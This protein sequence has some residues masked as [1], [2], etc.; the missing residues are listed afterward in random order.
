MKKFFAVAILA[1]ATLTMNAQ[2]FK[3]FRFGP[4]A[5]MTVSKVTDLGAKFG[6]GFQAG[7]RAD[8][9]FNDNFYLGS[10]FMLAQKGMKD[11]AVGYLEIPINVGYRYNFNDNFSMFGEAG[12]YVGIGLYGKNSYFDAAK[13]FDMGIGFALGTEISKFQIRAGYEYGLTYVFPGGAHNSSI[14][15]GLAYMF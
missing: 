6:V 7:V 9:N 11:Q 15:F 3:K 12:P 8:Y 13:R 4:T 5:G 10:A 14:F 1:L 2:D